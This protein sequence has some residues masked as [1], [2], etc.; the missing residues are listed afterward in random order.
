LTEQLVT[1]MTVLVPPSRDL[2]RP[3]APASSEDQL[4][5]AEFFGHTRP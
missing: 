2:F 3:P 4:G 1:L 5:A